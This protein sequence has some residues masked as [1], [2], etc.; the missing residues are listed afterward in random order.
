M[1]TVHDL[2]NKKIELALVEDATEG[3][4]VS[5]S[6]SAAEAVAESE[7]EVAPNDEGVIDEVRLRILSR[8]RSMK[9]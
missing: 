9:V 5:E 2:E 4:D 8:R 7:A 3:T 1:I 6:T